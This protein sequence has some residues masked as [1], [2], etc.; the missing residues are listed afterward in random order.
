VRIEEGR[1]DPTNNDTYVF[2]GM[3][4]FTYHIEFQRKVNTIKCYFDEDNK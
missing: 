1:G 2:G 4:T 3:L